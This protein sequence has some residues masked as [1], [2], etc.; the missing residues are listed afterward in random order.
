MSAPAISV[1]LP[2]FN[3]ARFLHGALDSVLS[4]TFS[5][6]E[7]VA[8]DDGSTDRSVE[9]LAEFAAHD[10]RIR[11][12][13]RPNTGIVGALADGCSAS[14]GEYLA[15]MDADDICMP[16]R[17]ACQIAYLR[18]HSDRVAVG[19]A[20]VFTDPA[21]RPLLRSQLAS[22]HEAIADQ[23]LAGNG[24]ALVHP[25]VMFRR[26]AVV[27][28][29]GYCEEFRHVEDLDLFLRLLDHGRLANLP[30]TVLHYR[31]HLGSINHCT[32][33]RVELTRRAVAPH[34]VLRGLPPLELGAPAS[35]PVKPAD[36]CRHWAYDAMRGGFPAS[37]RANAWRALL[38]APVDRR[39]WR[40]ARYIFSSA[41]IA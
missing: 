25:A 34:R 22:D 21:A 35:L 14:R 8:V 1:I 27:A 24:G 19:G 23:L 38:L 36:W 39:N 26:S 10:S 4:Q 40:C 37:A 2:V 5:D 7:I 9:I 13:S 12:I 33:V 15:R 20:V 18:S 11:V 32:G 41:A 31:Q 16:A 6:F 30:E 3:G 17:F 28:A 29:G